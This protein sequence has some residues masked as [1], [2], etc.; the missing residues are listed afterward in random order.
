MEC[1][2][3][4]EVVIEKFD[5]EVRKQE[6]H[7][8][9]YYRTRLPPP[10]HHTCTSRTRNPRRRRQNGFAAARGS[11]CFSGRRSGFGIGWEEG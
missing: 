11:F 4:E 8:H 10:V 1:A 9:Y 6:T 3:D 5:K 2:F 7:G